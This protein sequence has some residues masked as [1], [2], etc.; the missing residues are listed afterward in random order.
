M[1]TESENA[2]VMCLNRQMGVGSNILVWALGLRG[3]GKFVLVTDEKAEF[4]N[5]D[6]RLEHITRDVRLE[7]CGRFL[8]IVPQ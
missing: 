4:E 6:Q 3:A 2:R 7:V 5:T 8:L 1:K